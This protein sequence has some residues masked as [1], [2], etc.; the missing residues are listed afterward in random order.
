MNVCPRGERL[1]GQIIEVCELNKVSL[2]DVG[3]Q[4][5]LREGRGVEDQR[6]S[7]LGQR[8][9]DGGCLLDNEDL[10][11]RHQ[12]LCGVDKD[13]CVDPSA[14]EH[15]VIDLLGAARPAPEVAHGQ[16]DVLLSAAA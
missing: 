1:L 13:R 2:D 3:V 5:G 11:L 4:S 15:D 8:R 14:N 12:P 10:K 9:A 16:L 6:I 7:H